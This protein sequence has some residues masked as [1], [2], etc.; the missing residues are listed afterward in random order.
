MNERNHDNL[1]DALQAASKSMI[2]FVELFPDLTR[3]VGDLQATIM[4]MQPKLDVLESKFNGLEPS[5]KESLATRIHVLELWRKMCLD[6]AKEVRGM[7]FG[8][9]ICIVGNIISL[10]AIFYK[11]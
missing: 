6:D 11:H 2:G 5:G 4:R 1:M 8:L 9:F 3:Q 7:R 10:I